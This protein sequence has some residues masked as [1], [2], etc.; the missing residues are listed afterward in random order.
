MPAPQSSPARPRRSERRRKHF[1]LS[2]A[3]RSLP[4][5]SRIVR[6]I[7]E[8]HEQVAQLQT[9]VQRSLGKVAAGYQQ[10]LDR[11]IRQLDLYVSELS[12]LGV[13]LKDYGAGLVDFPGRNQDRDIC[14]C[15]KLGEEAILHWHELHAGY[16]G[17]QSIRT[18][19]EAN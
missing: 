9:Q 3:N 7:V 1:T 12:E 18:L 8:T 10:Q 4:L 2:E 16:A 15:W 17:R 6:D 11:S 13:E 5:V 14:L 19:K